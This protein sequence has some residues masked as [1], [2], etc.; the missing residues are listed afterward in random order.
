[1]MTKRLRE[2]NEEEDLKTSFAVFDK[3]GNG[4]ISVPELKFI[5]T[6]IGEKMTDEEVESMLREA[7]A[8]GD[9]QLCY[10]G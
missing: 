8:N 3:D 10:E 5:M 7:D 6:N 4:F 9:G 2:V 1:M